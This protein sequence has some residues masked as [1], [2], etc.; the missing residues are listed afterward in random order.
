V[1]PWPERVFGGR[2]PKK[3]RREERE[4]MPPRYATEVQTVINALNDLKQ[5]RV[6]WDCGTTGLGLLVSDSL[7][8]QRG[9]PAPSDPH[10]SHVY[11]LALPL[12]KR[13]M[14]VTPVQLENVTVPHCL[15]GF[16]VLLLSYHGQKPLSPE[17]HAPLAEWVKAGG[18][19]VVCD[20][21]SDP[22]RQVRE[23]WNSGERRYATP[24]EHLFE[25]LGLSREPTP[26]TS[27]ATPMAVGRGA[28]LW[29]RENP[30]KLAASADGDAR[31]LETVR[32]AAAHSRLTWKETNYLLLRRGPYVIG[33]GLDESVTAEPKVLR[34][35]FVNLFDPDLQVRE[36]VVLTPGA[37][38]FLLDLDAVRGSEPRVLASACKALPVRP[39]PGT[40]TLAVEGVARSPAV[41][42][43]SAPTAPRTV[44]LGSEPLASSEY[45]A[46]QRLLWLRLTNQS[47]PREIRVQF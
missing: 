4:P 31:L 30:A 14:P 10:L 42:L 17:V 20:D 2:Y 13:G 39:Q 16:R 22:C 3:V 34:G 18:V 5:V 21:D 47:A 38:V 32:R 19:L 6:A 11:G 45:S 8:F 33:A 26:N 35:R 27:P 29:L 28:V 36:S 25:Q 9:D 7:M 1:A 37:R 40:L 15:D 43:L 41:V 12:L 24:R 44:T 23:W 46:A